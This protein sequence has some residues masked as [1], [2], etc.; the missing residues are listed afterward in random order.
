METIS[1]EVQESQNE[2]ANEKVAENIIEEATEPQPT[3]EI[4]QEETKQEE[5]EEK[6]KP[7]AT[8]NKLPRSVK[9]VEMVEC[10]D[11]GKKMLPKSLKHSHPR[12]CKGQPSETLPVNKQK[13]S[14][15]SKLKEQMRKEIEDEMKSKYQNNQNEIIQHSEEIEVASPAEH[16]SHWRGVANAREAQPSVRTKAMPKQPVIMKPPPQRQ[17]TATELLQ[18][19]YNEMKKLKQQEKAEKIAKFKTSMF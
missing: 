10:N 1:N 8:A 11:C 13:N 14:Y 18:Q 2:E 7:K 4:Q 17:L 19:S 5:A 16:A 15:G 12:N 9:V 3:Q 6:P